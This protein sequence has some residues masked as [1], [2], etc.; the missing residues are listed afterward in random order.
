[1]KVINDLY[2]YENFKIV[3][4]DECFKFSL[5]SILLAEFVEIND[6]NAQILE[7]CAGN[8]AISL[9]LSYYYSNKITAVEIQD[10]IYALGKESVK[11]NKKES[12]ITFMHEDIKNLKNYF[13]GNNFDIV[14][15]NPP[16]FSYTTHSFINKNKIKSIARH[17]ILLKL[18]ELFQVVSYQL[19]N[20]GSF[21]L[22]HLPE[23][24]EEILFLCQKYKIT[25]KK[26]Q[27]IYTNPNKNATIVLIKCVKGANNGILVLPSLCIDNYKS[28]KNIFKGR[29]L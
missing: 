23:R 2:D 11:I 1:M 16:Y 19:K 6:A 15:A 20:N 26:I 28:Y 3:Q 29:S 10:T 4:E 22:V 13:P 24:L 12:Q 5:D 17:E 18:E 14:I 25:A 21:Y 9:I 8:G 7:L 27:F